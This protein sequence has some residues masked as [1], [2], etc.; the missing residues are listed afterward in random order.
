MQQNDIE[1]NDEFQHAKDTLN[2]INKCID[3]EVNLLKNKRDIILDQRK[4]FI[5]YFYELQDDEKRD[6]MQNEYGDMKA[7]EYSSQTI[8]RLGKQLNDPYFARIDFKE[9]GEEEEKF[10]IGI[11]SITHPVTGAKWV[12]DW[13]APISSLYYETEKGIASFK[14]PMGPV[15]G[16][17][18][19]KRRYVFKKGV[20]KKFNDIGMPSDDEML[21][22]VL[23]E[24]SDEHMK[25][26][27][28]TLQREQ[29]KIIRDYIEGVSVIS[30]CPGSGKTSIALHK[31]AYILYQFKEKLQNQRLVVLSPNDVFAEYIS[32]VLPIWERIA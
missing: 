21:V 20:L 32:T 27:V 1:S 23:S 9:D 10:Y 26:I 25:T 2:V 24:N 17:L 16:V 29:N 31:A 11:N 19:L 28:S 4:Y 3:R 13:R 5:D 15:N 6:L 30:G 8:S 22:E 7:Y 18:S 12:Y 14:A